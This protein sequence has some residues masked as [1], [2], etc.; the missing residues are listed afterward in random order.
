MSCINSISI[1]PL[2]YHQYQYIAKPLLVALWTL[3]KNH[4][5]LS[6]GRNKDGRE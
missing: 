5:A 4:T 3:K 6:S 2:K 1:S